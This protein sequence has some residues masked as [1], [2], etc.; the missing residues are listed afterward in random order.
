MG[1]VGDE[2]NSS[3]EDVVDPDYEESEEDFDERQ[4]EE[5]E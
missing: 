4:E 3:H 1:L 2:P 5:D